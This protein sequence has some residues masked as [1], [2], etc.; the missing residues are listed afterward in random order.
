MS[1]VSSRDGRETPLRYTPTSD[2]GRLVLE[3]Y[4]SISLVPGQTGGVAWGRG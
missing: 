1:A 3:S 2:E 4:L